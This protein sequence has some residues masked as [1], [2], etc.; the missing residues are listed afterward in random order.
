MIEKCYEELIRKVKLRENLSLLKSEIKDP[1]EKEKLLALVGDG[2]LLLDLLK[3]EEPKVRK[4]AALLLGDLGLQ[5]A[6]EPLWNAYEWEAT[7]FV[8]S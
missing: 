7:L 8:K 2:A 4:N 1:A 6:V 5:Q 3:E